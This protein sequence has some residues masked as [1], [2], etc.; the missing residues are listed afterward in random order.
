MN[1][2]GL[3]LIEII[4]TVGILAIVAL[5]FLGIFGNTHRFI[6]DAGQDSEGLIGEQMDIEGKITSRSS[7]FQEE[8]RM[9]L[10]FP[11]LGYTSDD[12]IEGVKYLDGSFTTFVAGIKD[13]VVAMTNFALND[14]GDYIILDVVGDDYNL[15]IDM[16]IEPADA[17]Y[18]EI[19]WISDNPSIVSVDEYGYVIATGASGGSYVKVT[20]IT[21]EGRQ[22]DYV[23]FSVIGVAQS[24]ISTLSRLQYYYPS[25][26]I[27]HDV[28]GF[29]P[30]DPPS[31][32]NYVQTGITELPIVEADETDT[33]IADVKITQATSITSKSGRVATIE[34]TAEDGSKSYYRVEFKQ[35]G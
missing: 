6:V 4:I 35:G 3:S 12:L 27:R 23:Y 10:L 29:V 7:G 25:D 30:D 34:V 26:G 17:T 19:T 14:S 16:V 9:D 1:K 13:Y 21:D 5:L 24:S 31:D 8:I 33:D 11:S 2:K 20:A 22:S 28:V 32:K 15:S 18:Q